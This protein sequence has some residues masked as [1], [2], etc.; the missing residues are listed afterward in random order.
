VESAHRSGVDANRKS[1]VAV[2][3]AE[4]DATVGL[5]T[6]GRLSAAC[7]VFMLQGSAMMTHA[8]RLRGLADREVRIA[9]SKKETTPRQ[10]G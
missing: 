4:S 6:G 10:N 3:A 8:K 7:A 2:R 9:C 1:A 5:T